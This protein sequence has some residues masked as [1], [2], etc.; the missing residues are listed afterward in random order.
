VKIVIVGGIGGSH[1]GD[2]FR[3]AALAFGHDVHYLDF[4]KAFA[5]FLPFRKIAWHLM[6]KRPANLGEFSRDVSNTC[7][8]VRPDFLIT[9]GLSPVN[10]DALLSVGQ[11]GVKRFNY[12]T[13]D[14]WN[15]AHRARWFFEALPHYD[16]VFSPRR[17]N[18]IELEA[19]GCRNVE[20][21]PFG[22]DP[23]LFYPEQPAN[24][25]EAQYF[26]SDVAFAGGADQ[27]RVDYMRPLI[28]AGIKLGL[29]GSY[30]ERYPETR[31]YTRG[32]ADIRTVRL[33]LT[34]ARISL[35]LVRRQNR[36]GN[37]M[38]TFEVP[39][40]GGCMLCEDTQ[41]HR[42]I[43]GDYGAVVTDF[44]TINEMVEKTQ[45]L[46]DQSEERMRLA[47]AAHRIVTTE[48]HTYSDRLRFMLHSI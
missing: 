14:P 12:L 16:T 43:F 35:C 1:I 31:Q 27:E 37:S 21:L 22:Y 9:T 3:R 36:D 39:A 18:M 19:A 41:E 30:W 4:S 6:G 20:Y 29:Y 2:S 24:E 44:G 32:Q 26:D 47:H 8:Q 13:D 5:A 25:A 38:R 10:R 42:D 48:G 40:V 11:L 17:A 34:N 33:A 28:S 23:E 15:P 46:L 45:W 7:K